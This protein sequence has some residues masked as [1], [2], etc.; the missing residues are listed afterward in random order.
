MAN[1][2][3]VDPRTRHVKTFER[4]M[5]QDVDKHLQQP[6]TYREAVGFSL[7]FNEDHSLVLTPE[8]NARL[9]AYLPLGYSVIGGCRLPDGKLFLILTSERPGITKGM[10][11]L[12]DTEMNQTETI[13]NDDLDENAERLN[14]PVTKC[15]VRLEVENPDTWRVY[16]ND[17]TNPPRVCTL[18]DR[19]KGYGVYWGVHA[20]ALQ[21]T[22]KWGQV[23]FDQFIEGNLASGF[24]RYSYRYRRDSVVSV[25]F[26]LSLPLTLPETP[27]PSLNPPQMG[28]SGVT[29]ER[30]IRV[31]IDQH[32]GRWPQI[33]LLVSYSPDGNTWSNMVV[34]DRQRCLGTIPQYMIHKSQAGIGETILLST[35]SDTYQVIDR[36]GAMTIHNNKLIF[37][38]VDH[39]LPLAPTI[40]S[41]R[42]E[43]IT[44]E[45]PLDDA[46]YPTKASDDA[47]EAAISRAANQRL[48]ET[49]RGSGQL[50]ESLYRSRS[51][52]LRMRNFPVAL[53]YFDYRGAQVSHR[54]VGF[55]RGERYPFACVLF[56]K[57][58]QPLF[59]WSLGTFATPNAFDGVPTNGEW[60]FGLTKKSGNKYYLKPVGVKV[61]GI[62]LP[63]TLLFDKDGQLRVSGIAIL[64]GPA[65]GRIL[66]QGLAVNT[67][68]VSEN[69]PDKIVPLVTWTNVFN[70]QYLVVPD[71]V[72][73]GGGF[74][75]HEPKYINYHCPDLLVSGSLPEVPVSARIR[76][77]GRVLPDNTVQL[78]RGMTQLAGGNLH[79]Y[80]KCYRY[81]GDDV[82]RKRHYRLSIGQAGRVSWSMYVDGN[83]IEKFDPRDTNLTWKPS[84]GV[85][86]ALQGSAARQAVIHKGSYLLR[87]EDQTLV[88][89]GESSQLPTGYTLVNYEVPSP[90]PNPVEVAYQWTGHFLPITTATLGD[91]PQT[92]ANG[93]TTYRLDDM[94]VWG[95]DCYLQRISLARLLPRIAS[96][97]DDFAVTDFFP[98]ESKYN[99]QLRYGRSSEAVGTMPGTTTSSSLDQQFR[100]SINESQTEDWFVNEG[101]QQRE[102]V[103]VF[104]VANPEDRVGTRWPQGIAWSKQKSDGERIDAYR[105][106]PAV[107]LY[108]LKG[109]YGAVTGMDSIFNQ[110]YVGQHKAFVRLLVNE[111]QVITGETGSTLEL[112]TGR[113]VGPDEYL[114]TDT[115]WQR[116]TA[117]WRSARGLY[118]IDE[119]SR[120][121]FRF[122]QAGIDPLSDRDGMHD[123][124]NKADLSQ[125]RGAFDQNNDHV[126]IY[127]S[128]NRFVYDE[129]LNAFVSHHRHT[130][131]IP[132]SDFILSDQAGMI[133]VS[134]NRLETIGRRNGS[135]YSLSFIINPSPGQPKEWRAG[136]FSCSKDLADQLRTIT[137]RVDTQTQTITL[138]DARVKWRDGRLW[139]P[140]RE[141]G[142]ADLH[143]DALS[144]TL[145]FDSPLQSPGTCWI[146]K[147]ETDY[148]HTHRR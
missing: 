82:D 58:G 23:T 115:G 3:F 127:N 9:L 72:H 102:T 26:P 31:Y 117:F 132:V 88:D 50:S 68:W 145:T 38:D 97:P 104:V 124:F 48:A 18:Q 85:V 143:G 138:P 10:L 66:H 135:A 54:K 63:S 46:G 113:E 37:G 122:S 8:A 6:G 114:S 83:E 125:L 45:M 29:T 73:S 14:S 119:L 39:N 90:D 13:Y 78:N 67:C 40:S 60:P 44:S 146:L 91:L 118:W 126:V 49:N 69:E 57:I 24:Y 28:V 144:I 108:L 33:E 2:P 139:I 30:G 136:I 19:T 98:Y 123:Y 52:S 43:P 15:V 111:R 32:D 87:V 112:S 4:G 101:L 99:L 12:V 20:F 71:T 56:D 27:S 41:V 142:R 110:L 11:M 42:L 148:N 77:I 89:A 65:S 120:K 21:P 34:A 5:R 81:R 147:W 75:V 84:I 7:R 109:E 59:A 64:R 76:N 140:L 47:S 116:P 134:G 61:S 79:V 70:S 53:D 105:L 22:V 74:L 141:R 106:L 107:N 55:R 128:L 129:A 16:W 62:E 86:N 95:G 36:A 35:L 51:G 17:F 94:E 130:D 133:N 131:F 103:R 92:T 137:L 25:P 93:V 96:G 1:N 80:T 121:L 100:N